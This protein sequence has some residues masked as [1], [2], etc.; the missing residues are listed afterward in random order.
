MSPYPA[1]WERHERLRDGT[2]VFVRPIKDE[3]AALYPDF[4]AAESAEDVRRRFFGAIRELSHEFIARLTHVDYA[5]AM[6]FIAID[7]ADGKMLGVVRLHCQD[8]DPGAGEYAVIVRSDFKGRGLGRLLMQRMIEWA[9]AARIVTINALV[10]ADNVEML[11]LCE[12]LGFRTSDYAPDR[13]IKRVTL[14]L[15][16][17]SP[18]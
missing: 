10:L 18:S 8:D 9:K 14:Q 5:R 11:K 1:A 6:A 15:G 12:E 7:E 2:R 13:G 16:D 3:D 17:R 4:V